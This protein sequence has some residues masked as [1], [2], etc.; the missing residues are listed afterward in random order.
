MLINCPECNKEVSSEAKSCIHCGFPIASYFKKQAIEKQKNSSN[1][2]SPVYRVFD[3]IQLI[4]ILITFI[5]LILFIIAYIFT[6][7]SSF[8]TIFCIIVTLSGI[9]DI[10]FC[11]IMKYCFR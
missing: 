3:I 11:G 7:I 6:G 5:F 2:E 4:G 1:Y 9:L 10:V 8:F